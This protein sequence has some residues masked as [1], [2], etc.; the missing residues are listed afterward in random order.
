MNPNVWGPGLWLTL[1]SITY[2]Y[3]ENPASTDVNHHR[4]FMTSLQHV[5]PC[6]GCRE[7]Y[8]KYISDSP[9]NL[10]TKDNFIQWMVDFHNHTNERLHKRTWTRAQ[11]DTLYDNIYTPSIFS[12]FSLNNTLTNPTNLFIVLIICI[13]VIIYICYHKKWLK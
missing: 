9:P 10:S 3:P 5:I 11:V 12:I 8:T 7:E 2:N 6:Q 13:I 1:H 4:T